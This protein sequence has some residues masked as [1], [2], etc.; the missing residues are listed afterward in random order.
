MVKI[1]QNQPKEGP[2]MATTKELLDVL[3]KDYKKPIRDW[4]SALNQFSILFEKRLPNF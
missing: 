1:G 3:M 2:I 4:K